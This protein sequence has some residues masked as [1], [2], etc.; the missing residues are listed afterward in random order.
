MYKREDGN[1]IK[2][3]KSYAVYASSSK[4]A[5]M[6]L[7]GDLNINKPYN[8]LYIVKNKMLVENIVEKVELEHKS[9]RIGNFKTLSTEVLTDDYLQYVDTANLYYEYIVQNVTI[10]KKIRF[11]NDSNILCIEYF[12]QND[13]NNKANIK[14]IPM[15]TY[16]DVLSFKKSAELNFNKYVVENGIRIDLSVSENSSVVLKAEAGKFKEIDSYLNNVVHKLG[17]ESLKEE[18]IIEDLYIPGE[19]DIKLKPKAEEIF[20]VFVATNDFDVKDVI[21]NEKRSARKIPK[22]KEEFIELKKLAI[23][24]TN[25]D[26]EYLTSSIPSYIDVSKAYNLIE[27]NINNVSYNKNCSN[28]SNIKFIIAELMKIVN[29]IEGQYL[30]FNE[31]K[32]AEERLKQVIDI[33]NIFKNI[34]S[35]NDMY[36]F[37]ILKLWT[38]QSLY[39]IYN[40]DKTIVFRFEK[41]II[42]ETEYVKELFEKNSYKFGN[43]E[44]ICLAYNLFKIYEVMFGNNKYNETISLIKEIVKIKFYDDKHKILKY[45]L[46]ENESYA[47]CEMIYSLSLAFPIVDTDI[48]IKILD[49]IFK[50][51]YTPYGLRKFSKFSDKNTGLIYPKYMAH[52]VI[53][54]L[55]QNGNSAISK[56]IVYNL[57]KELLQDIDKQVLNSCKCVYHEKGFSVDKNTLDLLT[58]A[59]I[60]R[61]YDMLT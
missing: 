49:T 42:D 24:K 51:L 52:F 18:T 3:L 22:V 33:V 16:K 38:M 44:Y 6:N 12:I 9:Y 20:R 5:Y 25:F 36:E 15:V 56:K 34:N 1:K 37:D 50:E 54:N 19:F 41:Y 48:G 11:L 30:V 61:L 59:E 14:I 35:I 57:V 58:T 46:K 7:G 45:S 31:V 55:R 60:I 47:T 21:E 4:E 2:S 43:L 32:K 10:A 17:L 39:N 27:N 53:A 29:A 23:A 28:S 40:V 8:G 13:S 26:N